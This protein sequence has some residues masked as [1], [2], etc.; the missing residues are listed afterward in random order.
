MPRR[1]PTP[2]PQPVADRVAITMASLLPVHSALTIEWLVDAAST[3]AERALDAPFAFTYFEDQQGRLDRKLPASD[4]RRRSVQRAIDALGRRALPA[5][6]DVREAPPIAEA[7]D[8]DAPLTGTLAALFGD[9]LDAAAVEKALGVSHAA[10]APLET[11]GERLGAIVL[12]LGA[13]PEPEQVR[14]FAQHVACA[15]VNL[16]HAQ[17]ARE[18]GVIDVVRSVFDARKLES[19]LQRELTRSDRYGHQLSIV[20]VEATNMRLLREQFGHFL[21]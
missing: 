5:R 7:L 1:N 19:E 20:T 15:A 21:P 16:R 10:I 9:A 4:L 3:A 8:A 18:H 2:S 6:I 14:L 11:A 17:S 13:T 12:L